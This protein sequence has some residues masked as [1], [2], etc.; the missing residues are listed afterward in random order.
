MDIRRTQKQPEK[1]SSSSSS[2]LTIAALTGLG[3]GL[4]EKHSNGVI[5][6]ETI[7]K[8][9]LFNYLERT[10]CK[11]LITTK[12]KTTDKQNRNQTS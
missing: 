4:D 10:G 8:F 2:G 3:D 5:E 7:E 11:K 6:W 12:H 9:Y 1:E